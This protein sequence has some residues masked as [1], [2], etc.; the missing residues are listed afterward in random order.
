MPATP[1]CPARWRPAAASSVS[2]G[3]TRPPGS[4]QRPANVPR[5]TRTRRTRSR[6]SRTVNTATSTARA[7]V[8]ASASARSLTTPP[9]TQEVSAAQLEHP[10]E[11]GRSPHAHVLRDGDIRCQVPE[12]V[13][14]ALERDHLHVLAELAALVELLLR[15]LEEQPV[16]EPALGDDQELA[17]RALLRV[18]DH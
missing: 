10:L 8:G 12:R 9:P 15:H 18:A 2:S 14:C 6:R 13:P 4:A 3:W 11:R 5:R 17:L 16:R 1:L 7:G